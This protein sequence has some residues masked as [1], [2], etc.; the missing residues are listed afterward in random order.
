MSTPHQQ[1]ANPS[2][3]PTDGTPEQIVRQ[4]RKHAWQIG[5]HPESWRQRTRLHNIHSQKVRHRH[6]ALPASTRHAISNGT[7][8][9]ASSA[10]PSG[11]RLSRLLPHCV[12]AGPDRRS[13]VTMRFS[14]GQDNTF[15]RESMASK[16]ADHRV[17]RCYKT[18]L[19]LYSP[20][21]RRRSRG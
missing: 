1:A 7:W 5:G 13:C 9:S 4:P 8:S 12:V 21:F 10:T 18:I 6:G 19:P 11:D 16:C 15:F 2:A 14:T 17:L 3:T 20:T